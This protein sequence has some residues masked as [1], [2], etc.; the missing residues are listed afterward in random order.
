MY[1][2]K[3]PIPPPPPPPPPHPKKNIILFSVGSFE[4]VKEFW[5]LNFYFFR[6]IQSFLFLK[7]TPNELWNFIFKIS[8]YYFSTHF[9]SSS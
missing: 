8:N 3:T 7:K 9:S 4:I 5:D 6:K 1:P 2:P